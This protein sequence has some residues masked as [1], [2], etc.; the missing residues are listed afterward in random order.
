MI[1]D[2][3]K[4]RLRRIARSGTVADSEEAITDLRTWEHYTGPLVN[5]FERTWY[6]EIARWCL[7]YRHDDL[8]RCNTNNGTERLNEILKYNE[9][10]GY[11]NCNCLN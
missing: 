4:A 3:V 6:P 8:F 2:N 7:A 5:Y 9:L 1:A 11:K 10:D